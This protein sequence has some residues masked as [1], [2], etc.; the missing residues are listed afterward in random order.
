MQ[1]LRNE[2]TTP[3]TTK[4]N[5]LKINSEADLSTFSDARC[6]SCAAFH[7]PRDPDAAFVEQTHWQT[8]RHEREHVRRRRDNGRENKDEHDGI[9]PGARHE[10][11]RDKSETDQR[12]NDNR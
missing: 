5:A 1:T 7:R 3:P 2:P 10:P 4:A 12:Q 9:R 11:M 6:R 8:H